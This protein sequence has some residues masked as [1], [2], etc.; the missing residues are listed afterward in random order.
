MFISLKYYNKKGDSIEIGVKRPFILKLLEGVSNTQ[1][2][3]NSYRGVGQDGETYQG[4]TLDIRIITLEFSI[5]GYSIED[6]ELKRDKLYRVFNPKEEGYLVVE[7]ANDIKVIKCVPD[8]PEINKEANTNFFD[9]Q[10]QLTAYDPYFYD[11]TENMQELKTLINGFKFPLKLPTKFKEFGPTKV[12]IFNNGHVATPVKILF[13]GSADNP[14][15]TNLTTGKF[16]K[17]NKTLLSDEKLEIT[18]DYGNKKVTLI[19]GDGSRENAFHYIDLNSEFWNLETGDNLVEYT[20]DS[21]TPVGV[22]VFFT[23]RYLGI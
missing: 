9:T 3:S 7:Y 13:V 15:V 17:V 12:N 4:S 2:N 23:E 16:I 6:A 1:T 11:Y 8:I 10:I 21:L 19:K 18:T 14:C 22:Q 5:W 20:T